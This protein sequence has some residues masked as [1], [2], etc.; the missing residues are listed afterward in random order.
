MFLFEVISKIYLAT[1]SAPVD[2][3]TYELCSDS[4]DLILD[5][6]SIYSSDERTD[7]SAIVQLNNG[8]VLCAHQVDSQLY[9]VMLLRNEN[10]EKQGLVEFNVDVIAKSIIVAL[11]QPSPASP[12]A[13]AEGIFV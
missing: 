13:P 10:F 1:D 7:G 3:A 9:L 12:P 2:M 6:A 5:M 11:K 8:M 4:L